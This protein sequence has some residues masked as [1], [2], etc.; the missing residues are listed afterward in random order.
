M[1][2]GGRKRVYAFMARRSARTGSERLAM[3]TFSLVS[4]AFPRTMA[5]RMA[6]LPYWRPKPSSTTTAAPTT[7]RARAAGRKKLGTHDSS[8]TAEAAREFLD[9]E[10]VCWAEL[11]SVS[12]TTQELCAR[13]MC[14]TPLPQLAALNP[15]FTGIAPK[16]SR[17]QKGLDVIGGSSIARKSSAAAAERTRV[18]VEEVGQDDEARGGGTDK[19]DSAD[20]T[21]WS[22]SLSKSKR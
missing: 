16:P 6:N 14:T 19:T 2:A 17:P 1:R 15:S 9:L 11:P 21:S 13:C 8:H 3:K 5:K 18:A 10:S 20:A 4:A 12:T 7:A 22:N